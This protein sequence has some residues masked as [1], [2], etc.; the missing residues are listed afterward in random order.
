[1]ARALGLRSWLRPRA[2]SILDLFLPEAQGPPTSGHLTLG[3]PDAR[4]HSKTVVSKGFLSTCSMQ[5]T[6]GQASPS[7]VCLTPL[8]QLPCGLGP[9]FSQ[10]HD[11]QG[12]CKEHL[13]SQQKDVTIA[14]TLKFPENFSL[15]IRFPSYVFAKRKTTRN[16]PH[17][18]GEPH[19]APQGGGSYAGGG[20]G[21]EVPD[22]G[23]HKYTEC[24]I[25]PLQLQQQR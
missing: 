13:Y 24:Q 4:F 5:C 22:A 8:P 9:T 25:V 3:G 12:C 23:T 6:Q 19:W 7:P 1:M 15:I 20:Q 10:D 18:A 2:P 21:W 17:G 16:T 14:T 11:P